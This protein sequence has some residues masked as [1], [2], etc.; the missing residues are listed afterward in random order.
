MVDAA[1][2]GGC[3]E[4]FEDVEVLRRCNLAWEACE[5]CGRAAL[6]S[7]LRLLLL[8]FA[9]AAVAAAETATDAAPPA[10][11]VA[12]VAVGTAC[13]AAA[14]AVAAGLQTLNHLP[15]SLLPHGQVGEQLIAGEF[16]LPPLLLLSCLL[17]WTSRVLGWLRQ[18]QRR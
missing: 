14:H 11:A 18:S 5:A 2:R 3:A 13:H 1:R 8:A 10:A 4:L 9:A 17:M 12:A 15:T 16:G 6:L 7:L